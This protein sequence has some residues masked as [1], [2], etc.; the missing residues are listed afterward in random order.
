MRF[1]RGL[2]KRHA[3]IIL[4][5]DNPFLIPCKPLASNLQSTWCHYFM[6]RIADTIL[7]YF[8]CVSSGTVLCWAGACGEY[9]ANWTLEMIFYKCKTTLWNAPTNNQ[10]RCVRSEFNALSRRMW[11]RRDWMVLELCS[12]FWNIFIVIAMVWKPP[13]IFLPCT[14]IHRFNNGYSRP[15][16]NNHSVSR[17]HSVYMHQMARLIGTESVT[18]AYMSS[19]VWQ[20]PTPDSS[21][22]KVKDS[23]P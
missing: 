15:S 3:H 1:S 21:I 16:L 13:T 6:T 7:D 22:G 17:Q 14:R 18:V 19:M 23:N 10:R 9:L 20:N 12:I 2:Y 8:C 11:W 5:N 4:L